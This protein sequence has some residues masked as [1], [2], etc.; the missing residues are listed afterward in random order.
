MSSTLIGIIIT[1]SA[2]E[3]GRLTQSKHCSLPLIALVGVL[4]IT[5]SLVML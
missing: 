4:T 2:I 5:V 3:I 1:I